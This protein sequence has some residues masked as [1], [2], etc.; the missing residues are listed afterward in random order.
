MVQYCT[1]MMHFVS[2]ILKNHS[3]NPIS[4]GQWP[5]T[6]PLYCIL[7]FI[8]L[9]KC[10]FYYVYE[11]LVCIRHWWMMNSPSM[12]YSSPSIPPE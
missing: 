1:F 11:T 3:T 7:T 12:L 9:L 5:S 6:I 8:S 4:V 10:Y 2:C